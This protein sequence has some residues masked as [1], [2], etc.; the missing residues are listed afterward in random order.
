MPAEWFEKHKLVLFGILL[1]T[2]IVLE[3]AQLAGGRSS[4]P[5]FAE[6]PEQIG[7]QS[8]KVYISGAVNNPGVYE[9]EPAARVEQAVELAGGPLENADL[10][11]I[12]LAVLLTRRAAGS[13]AGA[14]CRFGGPGHD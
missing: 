3:I 8:R 14:G 12:N 5:A 9:F 6:R 13:R 7:A 1:A 11:Q 4:S 2:I 10:D